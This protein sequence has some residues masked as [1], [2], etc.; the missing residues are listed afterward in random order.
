MSLHLSGATLDF[1]APALKNP[2]PLAVVHVS[3]TKNNTIIT[4]S[5]LTGRTRTWS[6]G[7]TVGE[8]NSRKGT[9]FAAELAAQTVGK[10]AMELGLDVVKVK[11]RERMWEEEEK[12][13]E[14]GEWHVLFFHPLGKH[15]LRGMSLF[16]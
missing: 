6:S 8:R 5:D 4:L 1:S 13:E 15:P 10:R 3:T 2:D 12:E 11:V 14:E 9:S 16:F 7:G